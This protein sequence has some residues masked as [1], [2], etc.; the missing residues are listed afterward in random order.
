MGGVDI[1]DQLRSYYNTQQPSRHNWLPLFFWLLDTSIV[2]S[3]IISLKTGSTRTHWE[4]RCK[5]V[6]GIINSV[7]ENRGSSLKKTQRQ[8][9]TKYFKLPECRFESDGHWQELRDEERAICVWCSWVARQEAKDS[10]APSHGTNKTQTWCEK[11]NVPLC[12]NS[13]RNCFKAFHTQ[14]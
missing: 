4:F 5:L 7:H 9:V 1:A 12:F 11:C 10:G 8:R 13:N 2:N 6:W 14:K 3:Y